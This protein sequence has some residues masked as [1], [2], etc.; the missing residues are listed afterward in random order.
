VSEHCARRPLEELAESV[1]YGLT[2]SASTAP[3][4]PRFLRI[5]DIQEDRVEW[6]SVPFCVAN[7]SEEAGC[8]LK[9]G[10][11][12][13][14]RTGA[15]TGKSYILRD[16][17]ERTVFAS[18]LIRVRPNRA[19]VE[20]RYLAW[21]FQTPEYWRQITSS[22]SGTAQPGVNASK[23]K[24][25]SVPVPS[26]PAQRRIADILDKA[27]AI[28]R[29][30]KEAIV[31]TDDLRRSVFLE[32]FG[33]PVANP[34]GWTLRPLGDLADIVGGG[35]PSR[36]RDD[37]FAGSIPWAT[38]KDFRADFLVDTE[39]HVS[40]EAIDASAAQVVPVGSLLVVVKSKILMRR[41]PVAI[42]TVP[43][44]FNQ[45]VKGIL[46]KNRDH[47][48]YLAAHLRLAQRSLLRLARG[49]NTE[50]L[51]INHLR[52]HQV[53]Q[54][55]ESLLVFFAKIEG[56]LRKDLDRQAQGLKESEALFASLV[57]RAFRGEL[58]T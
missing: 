14:A 41:L 51:T 57:H 35:T 53:M 32:M 27:D 26:L 37:F 30:R 11:I 49:V 52:T 21:Y 31:L 56:R 42:S 25:L 4:G 38:A 10:D 28:C 50:G 13:F 18:Y 43:M 46:P 15:T 23:L 40:P 54:P 8:Q 45:D 44:C 6:G 36:A 58:T 20:P 16:C 2:A 17:P 9:A 22:A 1:D 19:Q 47:S 12:V 24:A 48:A 3:V 33:D 34:K 5:T 39:E 29:K 7:P 55:P